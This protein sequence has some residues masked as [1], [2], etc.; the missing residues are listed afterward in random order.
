MEYVGEVSVSEIILY[1]WNC[2]FQML[3][4]CCSLNCPFNV[5]KLTC[6]TMD[7]EDH[8][9]REQ[10]LTVHSNNQF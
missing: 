7:S 5:L 8:S 9:D 3:V 1:C 2:L 10:I 4:F 6:L